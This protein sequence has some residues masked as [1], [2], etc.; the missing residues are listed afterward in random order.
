MKPGR[1]IAG[2]TLAA[3][4]PILVMVLQGA[5]RHPS[6]DDSPL[7]LWRAV[8]IGC[9]VGL[10]EIY[11]GGVVVARRHVGLA[12]AWLALLGLLAVVLVPGVVAELEG[13]HVWELFESRESRAW[14]GVA[15]ILL[16]SLAVA[17]CLWADVVSGSEGTPDELLLQVTRERNEVAARLEQV[18]G[19]VPDQHLT[20]TSADLTSTSPAP[21][22]TCEVC[23]K[24]FASHHARGGH[25]THCKRVVG[26]DEVPQPPEEVT[27]SS[28]AGA[29]SGAPEGV[30]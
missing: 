11:V 14:W 10:A 7:L 13:R 27:A 17:A 6:A 8:A 1:W 21:A 26:P 23:G 29:G 25:A 12:V 15:L 9:L 16:P 2:L 24:V 5:V 19:Q 30:A 3:L 22:Y 4:V 20:G 28:S 18:L